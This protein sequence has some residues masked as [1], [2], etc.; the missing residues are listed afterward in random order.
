MQ[1]G[2]T[3]RLQLARF[4][5]QDDFSC[6]L[7]FEFIEILDGV[8]PDGDDLALQRAVAG[9][10]PGFWESEQ[11]GIVGRGHAQG[12]GIQRPAAAEGECFQVRVGKSPIRELLLHIEVGVLEILRAGQARADAVGQFGERLHDLAVLHAFLADARDHLQVYGLLRG[13][14]GCGQRSGGKKEQQHGSG[15]KADGP[16]LAKKRH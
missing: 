3:L 12:D 6:Q 10:C 2:L 1:R 9:G 8:D 5:E 7:S 14:G 11:N 4:A 15:G 13:C 16:G